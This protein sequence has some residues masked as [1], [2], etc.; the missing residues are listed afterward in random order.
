MGFPMALAADPLMKLS[1]N[2]RYACFRLEKTLTSKGWRTWE[3]WAGR[4][5][6]WTFL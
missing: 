4:Y 3:A 6:R 1:R 2:V 5:S